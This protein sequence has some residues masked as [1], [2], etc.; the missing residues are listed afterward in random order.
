MFKKGKWDAKKTLELKKKSIGGP[1]DM[2][3]KKQWDLVTLGKILTISKPQ[4]AYL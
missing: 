2:L 4:F 1:S 3:G